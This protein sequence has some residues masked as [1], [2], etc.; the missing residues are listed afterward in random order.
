[1]GII[2]RTIIKATKMML[3]RRFKNPKQIRPRMHRSR[4]A[5]KKWKVDRTQRRLEVH[6]IKKRPSKHMLTRTLVKL[7][8]RRDYRVKKT[9]RRL[10][11]H[12]IRRKPRKRT[13][14]RRTK[15]MVIQRKLEMHIATKKTPNMKLIQMP[16]IYQSRKVNR[17]LSMRRGARLRKIAL[18]RV[19][20]SYRRNRLKSKRV[21]GRSHTN[22]SHPRNTPPKNPPTYSTPPLKSPP[23]YPLSPPKNPP[24]MM[25]RPSTNT[26][27]TRYHPL[28]GVYLPQSFPTDLRRQFRRRPPD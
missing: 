11:T 15:V 18:R 25:R 21:R 10:K 5:K 16:K 19:G 20:K 2:M 13:Y 22:K 9:Q 24:Q 27:L 7:I 3:K 6:A 26:K 8:I 1:M 12:I 23:T 14:T 4:I 17:A 28:M